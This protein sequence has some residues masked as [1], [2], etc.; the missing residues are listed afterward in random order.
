MNTP[1]AV[2]TA[3]SFARLCC[4]C[5]QFISSYTRS[6]RIDTPR[7]F[8]YSAATRAKPTLFLGCA[9]CHVPS[10]ELKGLI[11]CSRFGCRLNN[12]GVSMRAEDCTDFPWHA[13]RNCLWDLE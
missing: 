1:H 6:H 11:S 13:E 2:N 8:A 5:A 7:A 3:S 10:I 9:S 4:A 12:L